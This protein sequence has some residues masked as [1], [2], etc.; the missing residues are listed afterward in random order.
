[1]ANFKTH[2]STSTMLGIG[3]G[4]GAYFLWDVPAQHCIIA[5][6]L[7]S[8]AG[9]GLRPFVDYEEIGQRLIWYIRSLS[10]PVLRGEKQ[11]P[12]GGCVR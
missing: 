11:N 7:C 3:Y 12:T 1:M 8:V 5:A 10:L 6:G 4:I 9:H 2:I